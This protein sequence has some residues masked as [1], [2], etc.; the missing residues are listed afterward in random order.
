M[1]NQLRQKLGLDTKY[2]IK[3]VDNVAANILSFI[4]ST[5]LLLYVDILHQ[6]I[7][8]HSD[9]CRAVWM[10]AVL[11]AWLW[12]FVEECGVDNLPSEPQPELGGVDRVN[13]GINDRINRHNYDSHCGIG[14]QVPRESLAERKKSDCD[15]M[16]TVVMVIMIMLVRIKRNW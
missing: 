4:A 8:M 7:S 3:N 6:D 16:A 2:A 9:S 10:C 12:L 13:D 15:L 1:V 5:A 14:L 11:V